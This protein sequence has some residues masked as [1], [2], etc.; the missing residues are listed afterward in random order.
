MNTNEIIRLLQDFQKLRFDL[1]KDSQISTLGKK[2]KTLYEATEKEVQFQEIGTHIYELS[3]NYHQVYFKQKLKME[4][5]DKLPKSKDLHTLKK[6]LD[7]LKSIYSKYESELNI[8]LVQLK[9]IQRAQDNES[10]QILINYTEEELTDLELIAN[11]KF[12]KEISNYKQAKLVANQ[13]NKTLSDFKKAEKKIL[14]ILSKIKIVRE[15]GL[16]E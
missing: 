2:I 1:F 7:K 11:V 3:Q 16:H 8:R 12:R 6:Y 9:K 14:S 10:I 5:V 4:G 13:N 15:T